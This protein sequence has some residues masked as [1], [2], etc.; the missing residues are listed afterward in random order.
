MQTGAPKRV[1]ACY[2]T[3]M[4]DSETQPQAHRTYARERQASVSVTQEK[5][6]RQ[7]ARTVL[8]RTAQIQL[9]KS[10]GDEM[11]PQVASLKPQEM[12]NTAPR[13]R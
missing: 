11:A 12:A 4:V 7:T 5:M 10:I 8:D 3:G 9:F 1:Q 2:L 13:T 6:S